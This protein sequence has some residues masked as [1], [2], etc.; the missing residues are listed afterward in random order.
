MLE[1]IASD[2]PVILTFG[3]ER[4]YRIRSSPSRY[5]IPLK[6][7]E[8]VTIDGGGS[9]FVLEPS[10]RFLDVQGS[11]NIVIRRLRVD[12][13]PLPFADGVVTAVDA[14]RRTMTVR[15]MNRADL[16]RVVGGPTQED[17]EQAY[18]GM[19]WGPGPYGP[20]SRH[21]WLGRVETAAEASSVVVRPSDE[22][23]DY[24]GIVADRWH[25]SLPATGIAHRRG[26]GACFCIRDNDTV[27]LEDVELWSATW[28]GF[29]I[30]RN[31]GTLRFNRVHVRPKP[32]S[33]RL[34][35]TWRDAFHVKGNRAALLWEDCELTGMNDDAYNIST[36]SSVITRLDSP[37]EV[38]VKQKFP[39]LFIPWRVGDRLVAADEE[40]RQL[41]GSTT[42]AAVRE[43]KP[44][45]PIEGEPTA[46]SVHLTLSQ[47]ISRLATGVMA[48]NADAA[49]PNTVLRRC[50]IH[51]SCR[52]QSPVTLEECDVTALL[53][54]YAEPIEG[55]FPGP[56]TVKDCVLRRGRGNATYAVICSGASQR[57]DPESALPPR[58]LHDF[59]FLHNR[60]AGGVS[61]EGVERLRM[62][63]NVLLE[64][65]G[66]FV[67]ERNHGV[68]LS[69]NRLADG[70]SLPDRTETLPS[71]TR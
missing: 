24:S 4:T 13:D 2:R 39:L 29:E 25:I 8:N 58:A 14:S 50:R 1:R 45:P 12:Y 31:R 41:L 71:Q 35:S 55:P 40:S 65:K 17:G 36:H 42:I 18:F 70:T 51:Q 52:L 68:A 43:G 37:T 38:E 10:L 61:I 19:L 69:R 60:I 34:M 5:V 56:V 21:V 9:T 30:A 22:F 62:E 47:P 11:R 67:V 54:F 15:L 28:M 3:T 44:E 64:P 6:G 46:P 7:L 26:P 20:I 16:P 59:A 66:P 33:S 53:W 48:W 27:S 32:D 23:T 49:N 57:N 63:D